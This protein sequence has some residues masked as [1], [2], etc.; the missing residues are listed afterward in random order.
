MSSRIRICLEI[1]DS[2]YKISSLYLSNDGSFKI[3]I[4]YCPYE[5][6]YLMKFRPRYGEFLYLIPEKEFEQKF[7][8]KNRPQ[9]SIHA[10]GFVQFSGPGVLSGIDKKTGLANG[11]GIYSNPLNDPIQSGPT[12][13]IVFWGIEFFEKLSGSRK[14]DLII[15]ENQIIDRPAED[16]KRNSYLF[17]FFVFPEFLARHIR[18]STAGKEMTARFPFYR[19]SPGAIFT[20]PIIELINHQSFIGILP[21]KTSTGFANKTKFGFN[22]GSPSGTNIPNGNDVTQLMALSEKHVF[23]IADGT[24]DYK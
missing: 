19:H 1:K 24:L 12:C 6:G 2:I 13:G 11:L 14:T 17:E 23:E 21:F 10:S 18:S 22:F 5:E 9:L 4:P 15:R 3:D 7:T 16:I 8:A 20:F